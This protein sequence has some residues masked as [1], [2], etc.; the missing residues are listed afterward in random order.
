MRVYMLAI[1][2]FILV[3]APRMPTAQEA[4][5]VPARARV[6]QRIKDPDEAELEADIRQ[7]RLELREAR[8][9]GDELDIARGEQRLREAYAALE[10]SR[11]T[12]GD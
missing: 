11:W 4:P 5:T 7:R 1:A 2:A 8:R 10:E 3:S 12:A 9:H 6:I